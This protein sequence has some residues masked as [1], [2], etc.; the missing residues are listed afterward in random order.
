MAQK[1]ATQKQ[2]VMTLELHE[3]KAEWLFSGSL[4]MSSDK[5]PTTDHEWIIKNQGITKI[6]VWIKTSNVATALIL[7][8][9][10]SDKNNKTIST[11]KNNVTNSKKMDNKNLKL[12]SPT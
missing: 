9:N 7:I 4:T 11:T 3:P 8:S 1:T 2:K 5:H 10:A 12:T 6:S